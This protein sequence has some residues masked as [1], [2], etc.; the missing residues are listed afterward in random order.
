MRKPAGYKGSFYRP[1]LRLIASKKGAG[2]NVR[3][4]MLGLL[5][6][7]IGESGI[8]YCSSRRGVDGL[9]N[10][11]IGQGVKALPY[12][13]GLD[14]QTR[15]RHQEAFARDQVEVIVATI[16]FGMGIDK[17]NVRFVIHREMPRNIESWYQEIGRAGRD[18]LPSDCVVFYSWAD[19]IAYD[20][21]L[22]EIEDQELR[23]ET[24]A[25]TVALFR[26]LER[27]GCRHQAL[28]GYFDEALEPC[29]QA[30]DHCLGLGLDQVIAT[31][32][33]NAAS[34]A[35]FIAS[36][37]PML[38]QTAA[39]ADLFERLRGLRRQLADAEHVPAYVVFSDAVLREMARRRP[40]TEAAL[41]AVPGVGHYKLS[42]YGAAFLEAVNSFTP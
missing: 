14:D 40:H 38:A 35:S 4:D 42:R 27:A 18:G 11:L 9:T 20:A 24:R 41:L 8:I 10:W 23:G 12:H 34:Q 16:A 19:V 36:P 39:E 7:H 29:G 21:F 3:Q 37:R 2:R 15:A 22:S 33:R 5:R 13:A 25:R 1:N 30:C 28:V 32:R 6:G 26:L 31:F 17:S